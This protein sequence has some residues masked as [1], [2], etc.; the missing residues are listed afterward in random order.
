MAAQYENYLKALL[1]PLAVYDLTEGTVN[2][3]ELSSLGAGM[4]MLGERLEAVERESLT[5][6]AEGEGLSR[7][8]A[9]FARKPAAPTTALRRAAIAALLRIDGD[10][11]TLSDINDTISGCGIRAKAEEWDPAGHIRVTFPDVAGEPEGYEQIQKIILDI[12]PCHL[13]T[14]FYLRYLTWTECERQSFTWADVQ[15]AEYTWKTFQLA[16]PPKE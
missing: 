10:S 2:E 5:A 7:R 9:L 11:L 13:E 12:I 14:E 15:T 4:D 6:T 8:E 3:S 16:V 1:A